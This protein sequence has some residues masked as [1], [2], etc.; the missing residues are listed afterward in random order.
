MRVRESET[1]NPDV[2]TFQ[3]RREAVVWPIRRGRNGGSK[4]VRA[5]A[6]RTLKT[7]QEETKRHSRFC[8][9]R[10]LKR[11]IPVRSGDARQNT[12]KGLTGFSIVLGK[13]VRQRRSS[14]Q[15]RRVDARALIADEG[16][17]KLR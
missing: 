2:K 3:G 6:R 12:K 1:S 15:E 17:D 10:A 14:E 4:W 11:K 5:K 8:E 13:H 7:A 9:S 16:R